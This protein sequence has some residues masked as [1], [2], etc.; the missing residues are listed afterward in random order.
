MTAAPL[1]PSPGTPGERRGEGFVSIA[2]NLHSQKNPHPDPLPEYRARG[3]A[4]RNTARHDM[5]AS[6][7]VNDP[8]SAA[9]TS[10]APPAFGRPAFP[11][12]EPTQFLRGSRRRV[13][14]LR[15]R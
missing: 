11:V 10:E 12:T 9:A 1:T 7:A 14:S 2:S 5:S 3:D 4:L 13:P 6:L 8:N 15:R